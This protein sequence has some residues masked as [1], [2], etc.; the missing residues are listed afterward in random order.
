MRTLQDVTGFPL[1]VTIQKCLNFPSSELL[2]TLLIKSPEQ[3]K[4][5]VKVAE[6]YLVSSLKPSL[7]EIKHQAT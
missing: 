2:I 7:P 1:F 6:K 3:E 5:L 4:S